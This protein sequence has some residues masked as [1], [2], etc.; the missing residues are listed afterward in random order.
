MIGFGKSDKMIKISGKVDK[1]TLTTDLAIL[2][3]R[4]YGKK[5]IS[6]IFIENERNISFAASV[7][8]V[9]FSTFL[10]IFIITSL[11]INLFGLFFLEK[12]SLKE[13]HS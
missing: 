8:T 7:V 13:K 5:N 3:F 4:S 2:I 6:R 9:S 1:P 11:N 12:L 10:L